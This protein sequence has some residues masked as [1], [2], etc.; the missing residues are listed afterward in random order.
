MSQTDK[1]IVFFNLAVMPY[2][3]AVFKALISKGYNCVVYW[4]GTAPKTAYRAPKIQGLTQYNRFDYRSATELFEHSRQFSPC[5]V[6]CGGWKD[7][8]YNKASRTYKQQNVTT[9][10]MSDTQWRGGRQWINV[11]LSPFRHKRYFEYIWGAGILQF[12]YARK[13]GFPP[14]RILTNCLAGDTDTFSKVKIEDKEPNYPKRFLF[15]GRFIEVKAI[16]VLL[17]AWQLI[18]NKKGWELELIGDGPLKE[19]FRKEYPDVIFKDFM[20]QSELAVEAQQ[21]G[22]FVIPSRFEPWALVIQEFASAGLPVIATR[23]CGAARHFVLN[24]HNGYI[25]EAEDVEALKEAM[26]NIINAPTDKLLYYSRNSRRL[27]LRVTPEFV[28]DTLISV[29]Q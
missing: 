15:V 24:G 12:D 9:L 16:D 10:A 2:H 20:A 26:A 29:I 25:V 21:S 7:R 4:Y 1:N 13:L 11:I 22:C 6:V 28:A 3:V 8:G 23:Q 14:E 5:V 17:K 18:E 27:A 19:N